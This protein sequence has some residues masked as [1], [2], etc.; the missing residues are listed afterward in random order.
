MEKMRRNTG[1]HLATRT[2][3]PTRRNRDGLSVG[4]TYRLFSG[5]FLLAAGEGSETGT[6]LPDSTP[7]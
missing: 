7:R 4:P 3:S 1:V 5:V 6:R 2:L